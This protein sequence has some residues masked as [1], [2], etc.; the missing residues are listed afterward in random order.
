MEWTNL[1]INTLIPQVPQIINNNFKSFKRYLDI[2]YNEDT[3]IIISPIETTGRIKGSSGEFT[4]A[5]IEN[6][7]VKNQYTNLYSNVNTAD[8][9]WYTAYDGSVFLTR[10]PCTVLWENTGF[11]YIDV[12]KPYYKINNDASIALKSSNL[13]QVVQFIFDTSVTTVPFTFLTNPDPSNLEVLQISSYNSANKWLALECVGWDSSWGASWAHYESGNLN[14]NAAF[15]DPSATYALV[16]GDN[17]RIIDASGAWTLTMPDNLSEGF[18]FTLINIGV[19]TIALDASNLL[20]KNSSINISEQ[21]GVANGV[22]RGSG[23]WYA[24]GDLTE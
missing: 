7:I 16:E 13:S 19:G 8:Y 1:Y 18:K 9:D 4:T 21:Y 10:D 14:D 3:G 22:H 6:L 23:T 5:V 2:F 15:Y 17:G 11:Q 24:W 20:T 12:V